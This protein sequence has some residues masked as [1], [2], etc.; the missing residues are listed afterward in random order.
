MT[1][2]KAITSG[3]VLVLQ[4]CNISSAL[5]H[6]HDSK[7]FSFALAQ[8]CGTVPRGCQASLLQGLGNRPGLWPHR[9]GQRMPASADDLCAVLPVQRRCCA[10]LC[11]AVPGRML[12]GDDDT[13]SC[14]RMCGSC[15]CTALAKVLCMHKLV[16]AVV[17]VGCLNSQQCWGHGDMLP[18]PPSYKCYGGHTPCHFGCFF[19]GAQTS[20]MH[21]CGQPAGSAGMAQHQVALFLAWAC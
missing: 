18:S 7:G 13:V 19:L 21:T 14:T 5:H 9:P 4:A 10:V 12:Y 15:S 16:N 2:S 8:V 3:K 17:V 6:L 20:C 1:S 11:C